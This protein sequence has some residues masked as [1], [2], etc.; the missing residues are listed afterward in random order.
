MFVLTTGRAFSDPP[1]FGPWDELQLRLWN[2][3]NGTAASVK[4]AAAEMREVGAGGGP[5]GHLCSEAWCRGDSKAVK[6]F[7]FIL[8]TLL[9]VQVGMVYDHSNMWANIQV[10]PRPHSS[11][12][13]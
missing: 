1:D 13:G 8:A 7:S 11:I 2:P 4:D 6:S 3:L 9:W 5:L 10:S 12:K